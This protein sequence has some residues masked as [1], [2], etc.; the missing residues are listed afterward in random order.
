MNNNRV[1]YLIKNTSLLTISQFSSKIL[2]FFLVPLY[3][4]VLSTSD[5]G[6][7]DLIATTVQLLMPIITIDVYEGAMRFVMDDTKPKEQVITIGFKFVSI[8]ILLFSLA[9]YINH[10]FRFWTLVADYSWLVLLYFSFGLLNQYAGQLAKGFEQVRT[11]AVSGIV[12]TLIIVCCNILFLLVFDLGLKGF[13]LAYII[14]Y[15]VTSSYILFSIKIYKYINLNVDKSIQKEMLTFSAPLIF[16]TLGWWANSAA[17]RYI[18]TWLCGISANGIYSV[19][20]KI[21]SI[22]NTIQGIFVQAWQISAIKEIESDDSAFFYGNA[23]RVINTMMCACCILLISITIP[24]AKILFANDFFIAWKY[25]PFL[26]ISSV[27]NAAAG[28]LGPILS[29]KK[30][31]NSMAIAAI[32][33]ATTNIILNVVLVYFIG[34]QGAAISTAISSF[35]IYELRLKAVGEDIKHQNSYKI[36]ASWI[37]MVIQ[38][39]FMIYTEMY[40]VQGIIMVVFVV[41]YRKEL[42]E[43]KSIIKGI[44]GRK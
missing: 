10:V 25:V 20:Y 24:I 43:I 6:A 14:G 12:G 17:D 26:L 16:N 5:Y 39:F 11:M 21:P 23:L 38:S 3:T 42:L 28:V 18:V 9:V 15:V 33:G 32:A 41:G 31:S 22:L 19:S 34:V 36:L 7:Y 44:L 13:F 2:V 8:G 35:V 1:S 27:I 37:L 40:F 30:D 29:A 4:S